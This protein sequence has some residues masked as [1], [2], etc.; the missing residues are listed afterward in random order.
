MA[1]QLDVDG[2]MYE[3]L[4][5]MT[6]AQ[7]ISLGAAEKWRL[8]QALGGPKLLLHRMPPPPQEVR[9]NRRWLAGRRHSKS[10]DANAISHHY[11]VSNR[12][13]EW[14]LGPSMAYTCAC[15][16]RQDATLEEAQA[17]KFDLVAR[18][19]GLQR[20]HAPARRGLRLGRHGHARRPEVRRQ[21]ARRHA[22]RAAGR[23]GAR[24][25][26]S[27]T[28]CPASPRCGTWTTAT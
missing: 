9:I 11:D 14:V 1:G 12:F 21:G 25:P 18:K 13:Y 2:D 17:N 22:V 7:S 23:V 27:A 8:L 5:R 10:R 15:Y 16:P 4:S 6:K 24:T 26:S 28:A 3:A 20:G 19:L